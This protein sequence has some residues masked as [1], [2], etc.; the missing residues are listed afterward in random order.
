MT[1]GDVTG[2]GIVDIIAGAGTD[3]APQVTVFDGR[4]AQVHPFF[5]FD[6]AIRGGVAVSTTDVNGDGVAD[7]IAAT[8]PGNP[9]QIKAFDGRS[10]GEIEAFTAL[11]PTFTGGVFVG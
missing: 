6:P 1:A 7:I 4:T 9:P 3:G 10:L 2:D 5:A 8:G 11:D